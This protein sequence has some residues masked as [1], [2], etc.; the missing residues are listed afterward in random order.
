MSYHL[1]ARQIGQCVGLGRGIK[2]YHLCARNANCKKIDREKVEKVVKKI[3]ERK[4]KKIIKKAVEGFVLDDLNDV[5][6]MSRLD[7]VRKKKQLEEANK[8]NRKEQKYLQDYIKE[9]TKVYNQKLKELGVKKIETPNYCNKKDNKNRS[10]C[11]S[12][13]TYTIN[14]LNLYNDGVIPDKSKDFWNKHLDK[15]KFCF[16]I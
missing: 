13:L 10:S 4:S 9:Y 6:G 3:K 1:C 14:R 7:I 11:Q 15:L 12:L 8:G 16:Q 2:E 5:M